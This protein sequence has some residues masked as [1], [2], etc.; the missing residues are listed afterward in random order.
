LKL[1]LLGDTLCRQDFGSSLVCISFAKSIL[2][3]DWSLFNA[4]AVRYAG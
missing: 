1:Q 3:R 4:P 2:H